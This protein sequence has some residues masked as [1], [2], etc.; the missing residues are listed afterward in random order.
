MT[1]SR[2]FNASNE[3]V[4][5]NIE[6][7][8]KNK[9]TRLNRKAKN[10]RN[11]I[12]EISRNEF[13][14]HE[15]IKKLKEKLSNNT[16]YI[17]VLKIKVENTKNN[18]Y[19]SNLLKKEEENVKSLNKILADKNKQYDSI[20][21]E[22][23]LLNQALLEVDTQI[24][25][26]KERLEEVLNNLKNPNAYIDEELKSSDKDKLNRLKE[27]LESLEKRE[28]ELLTDASVIGTEA[29][30]LLASSNI[31]EAIQKI[32]ELV[33]IV[34][35]K[36][37]MDI[38]DSKTL[39]EE[40]EKKE[41]KRL[42]LSNL[43]DNKTYEGLESDYLAKR[44][45]SIEQLIEQNKNSIENY[46]NKIDEIDTYINNNLG[47]LI[48]NIEQEILKNE[49]T[50]EEY[51]N[52]YKDKNKT[53]KVKANLEN[54]INK[55]EKEKTILEDLLDSYK[56]DLIKKT[57]ETNLLNDLIAKLTSENELYKEENNKLDKT[58]MF[59]FKTKDLI[60]EE[61]R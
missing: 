49:K 61:K 35:N 17:N 2:Y 19:Y 43:I 58:K 42:E 41:S 8:L 48:T 20:I 1:D 31:E 52:L 7:S 37:Y 10:I 9:I 26:D 55:K 50:L 13:K 53:S 3:L 57:N 14:L 29:K 27:E 5:K 54:A 21:K 18:K 6:I 12:E 56:H 51:K 32:K 24:E 11:D 46:K 16:E 59:D 44:K 30:E 60:E 38:S 45:E 22:L 4:D 23:D 33:T 28:L 47:L 25:K 40:L 15:E 34:K 39:E 36:P